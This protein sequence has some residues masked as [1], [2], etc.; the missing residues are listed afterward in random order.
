MRSL[1]LVLAI[2]AFA[3]T[4]IVDTELPDAKRDGSWSAYQP[5]IGSV[6]VL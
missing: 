3:N 2:L 6:V 1:F 5:R 4:A